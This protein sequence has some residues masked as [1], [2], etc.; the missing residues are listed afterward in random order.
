VALNP[1]IAGLLK[2]SRMPYLS[3]THPPAYTALERAAVS[4]TPG[5]CFVKVVICLADDRPVQAVLPAHHRV[6][7]E[8]LRAIAGA[9]TL[10]LACEGE[11][12]ALYPDFE[13]GAMPPFGS[14]YGHRVFVEHC[15]VGEPDMVFNGGTHHDAVM[16]HY[17]DFAEIVN[18]VVGTF[19]RCRAVTDRHS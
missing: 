18:P 13:V 16:M 2:R 5:R 19:G 7:F 15:L 6:D 4:H 10:R 14:E 17:L 1:V 8:Q 11:V 12:A 3:F 9:G